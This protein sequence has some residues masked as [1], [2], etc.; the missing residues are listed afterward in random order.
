MKLINAIGKTILVLALIVTY[1]CSSDTI[2]DINSQDFYNLKMEFTPK[3]FDSDTNNSEYISNIRIVIAEQQSSGTEKI[4]KNLKYNIGNNIKKYQL[5]VSDVPSG[6]YSIYVFANE[7]LLEL[8]KNNS[9]TEVLDNLSYK[10]ELYALS[11]YSMI[12]KIKDRVPY[13]GKQDNVIIDKQHTNI[14]VPLV[15]AISKFIIEVENTG[16]AAIGLSN[17]TFGNILEAKHH[18]FTN[19]YSIVS[20]I[21]QVLNLNV[22]LGNW[23]VNPSE[24]REV[25]TYLY[26]TKSYNL[27]PENVGLSLSF[28]TNN[29]SIY[30][31]IKLK[32]NM[33]GY[34]EHITPNTVY[35]IKAKIAENKIIQFELNTLEWDKVESRLPNYE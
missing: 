23:V 33:R 26:E 5:I 32:E 13:I 34:L 35:S 12:A 17:V 29:G 9:S 16:D 2:E 3:N 19:E 20:P 21:P 4:V 18:L 8:Q 22:S 10:S 24:K 31:P 7:D 30:E 14:S 11:T 6:E 27:A 1:G 28:T 25:A 15:R